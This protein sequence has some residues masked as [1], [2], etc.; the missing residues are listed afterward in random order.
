MSEDVI[1][2]G[3]MVNVYFNDGT[4]MTD[5][6]VLHIPAATGDSWHLRKGSHLYYIQLFQSMMRTE[7]GKK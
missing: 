6:V 2:V 4:E 3:D 1:N 5:Y 7:R